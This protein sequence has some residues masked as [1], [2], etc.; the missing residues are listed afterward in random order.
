MQ[1]CILERVLVRPY[2]VR[3]ASGGLSL[4]GIDDVDLL[5]LA[6]AVPVVVGEVHLVLDGPAGIGD[7]LRCPFVVS[8]GSAFTVVAVRMSELHRPDDIEREVEPAAA[9]VEEVVV[10]AADG[11]VVVG[12]SRHVQHLVVEGPD[13]VLARLERQHVPGVLELHVLELDQDDKPFL[14]AFPRVAEALSERF[15]GRLH[16][17][18]CQCFQLSCLSEGRCRLLL[19]AF[20]HAFCVCQ[21]VRGHQ[22]AAVDAGIVVASL[23]GQD[24][25]AV[26]REGI[27][28]VLVA[29]GH[30]LQHGSVCLPAG[31]PDAHGR[32]GE[33]G[34]RQQYTGKKCNDFLHIDAVLR[35][36][37]Y[38]LSL[39]CHVLK[40]GAK[41]SKFFQVRQ[42]YCFY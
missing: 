14:P 32:D 12:I 1:A 33:S 34:C 18:L 4:A 9:L 38:F 5:H 40:D 22:P 29:H 17:L 31:A 3:F 41:V 35:C 36:F 8:A 7:H 15:G 28:E 26:F 16:P 13:I 27:V 37:C 11:P 23:A 21:Y 10:Y 20:P 6:V 2:R 42:V 39:K 24:G 19:P 30:D 25:D